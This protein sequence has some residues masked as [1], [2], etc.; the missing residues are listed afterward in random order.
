M[1]HY[2]QHT[3]IIHTHTLSLSLFLSPSLSLSL[4]HKNKEGSTDMRNGNVQM[5]MGVDGVLASRLLVQRL[6]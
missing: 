3:H 5:Q 1:F 4:T 2:I 6:N